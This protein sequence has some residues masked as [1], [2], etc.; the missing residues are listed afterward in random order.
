MK[1]SWMKT[2]RKK[3]VPAEAQGR[4]LSFTAFDT[5][6]ACDSA[7]DSAVFL[8]RSR[9]EQPWSNHSRAAGN[10]CGGRDG[11]SWRPRPGAFPPVLLF[12]EVELGA[13][14]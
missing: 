14:Q 12:I 7:Y 9:D 2:R 6:L 5:R 3:C 10:K 13:P 4:V 1:T 11:A 8:G